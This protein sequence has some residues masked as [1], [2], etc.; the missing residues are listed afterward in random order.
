MPEAREPENNTQHRTHSKRDCNEARL[1]QFARR[2]LPAGRSK[3]PAVRLNVFKFARAGD[4]L[5]NSLRQASGPLSSKPLGLGP[6]AFGITPLRRDALGWGPHLGPWALGPL[7][8]WRNAPGEKRH[9]TLTLQLATY[10]CARNHSKRRL[11]WRCSTRE[12]IHTV[13]PPTQCPTA[14]P[15]QAILQM[16]PKTEA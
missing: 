2:L 7:A 1:L 13:T 5:S 4:C 8:K 12:D 15:S 6:F 16:Q 3:Q 10:N 9:P 11:R 14:Q